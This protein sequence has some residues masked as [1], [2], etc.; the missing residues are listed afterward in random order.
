VTRGFPAT[1]EPWV[2]DRRL[3]QAFPPYN[4]S[5]DW[6][7]NA[8]LSI[9]LVTDVRSPD[10]A[11]AA[12]KRARLWMI[13]CAIGEVVFLGLAF[14]TRPDEA[15]TVSLVHVVHDVVSWLYIGGAVCC[16]VGF[17]WNTWLWWRVRHFY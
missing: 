11:I 14:A 15:A 13:V 7:I 6:L 4:H 12:M 8:L 10:P 3:T 5:M 9:I 1:G 16:C 17:V 2:I